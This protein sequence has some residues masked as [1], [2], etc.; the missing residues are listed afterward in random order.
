MRGVVLAVAAWVTVCAVSSPALAQMDL[1]GIKMVEAAPE[2]PGDRALNCDQIAAEMGEIMNRRG[3]K[4]GVASAKGKICAS[5]KTLDR[6]GDERKK[7]SAAQAPA[8]VTA[9]VVG[10]PVANAVTRTTAAQDA[11]LEAKQRPERDRAV[12]GIGSGVT[13]MLG[14]FNDPRLM[15]LS[16]LAQTKQC[17]ASMAPK[18][19]PV[20]A[21]A[22]DGCEDTA[23]DSGVQPAALSRASPAAPAGNADP[24]VQ[25][26]ATTAKPTLQ[27][28]FVKR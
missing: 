26:G 17:G 22:S 27:D 9:S 21:K 10:G 11:A 5:R 25:R 20:T 8:L 28:P 12:S 16:M 18:Q 7:L 1:S 24:F 23:S 19:E 14:V 2:L 3:M 13:D 15:R 6:Q 4:Q